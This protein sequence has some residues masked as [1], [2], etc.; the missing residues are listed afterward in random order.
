MVLPFGSTAVTL[1]I[2]VTSRAATAAGRSPGLAVA[3]PP[4]APAASPPL[5]FMSS[6]ASACTICTTTKSPTLICGKFFTCSSTTTSTVLPSG[7]FSVRVRVAFSI[8]IT[9]AVTLIVRAIAALP[10]SLATAVP[11]VTSGFC[12][13]TAGSAP[14]AKMAR[15]AR[16]LRM[17]CSFFWIWTESRA[18][19]EAGR[20]ERQLDLGPIPSFIRVPQQRRIAAAGRDKLAHFLGAPGGSVRLPRLLQR[21]APQVGR[22]ERQGVQ[23]LHLAVGDDEQHR[24]RAFEPPL[25]FREDVPRIDREGNCL[26][27]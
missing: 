4:L 1:A 20:A 25:H 5:V 11:P 6:R 26:S 27:P 2:A 7:P 18:E 9:C 19:P 16:V 24:L 23:E 21:V 8:D 22:R 17:K 12:W 3:T 13:A 10:G 14:Q 15:S